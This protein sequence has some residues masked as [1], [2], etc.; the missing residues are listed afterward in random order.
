M[1][2]KHNYTYVSTGSE[3][4]WIL[5]PYFKLPSNEQIRR[6]ITPE[7]YCA[8]LSMLSAKQRLINAGVIDKN[9]F[10]TILSDDNTL[11]TAVDIENRKKEMHEEVGVMH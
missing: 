9:Q 2:Y 6:L 4:Y 5:R 3:N 11:N 1:F 10:L 7:M 8:L